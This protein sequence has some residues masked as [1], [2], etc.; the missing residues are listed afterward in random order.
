MI[1]MDIMSTR[2]HS[3]IEG[4]PWMEIH[5]P[6]IRIAEKDLIF[7]SRY[8]QENCLN[9]DS[10]VEIQQNPGSDKDAK[11]FSVDGTTFTDPCKHVLIELY[12]YLDVFNNR[13]AKEMPQ[14]RCEYNFRINF[15]DRWEKKL[16]KPAKRHRLTKAEQQAE[17]ETLQE[18]QEAKMIHPSRSPVATP[19]FFIPKKV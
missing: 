11:L 16:P 9:I 6:W 13:K 7:T 19:T 1:V 3:L 8:C 10:H 12:N 14:D 17:L 15:I 2:Q 4:M 5:D 18:L